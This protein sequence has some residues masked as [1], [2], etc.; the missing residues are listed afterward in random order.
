V[1][2]AITQLVPALNAV[3][4]TNQP[5]PT[6]VQNGRA[7]VVTYNPIFWTTFGIRGAMPPVTVKGVG[8]PGEMLWLF[9]ISANQQFTCETT[10]GPNGTW[11]CQIPWSAF[12]LPKLQWSADNLQ[13]GRLHDWDGAWQTV[14]IASNSC[15]GQSVKVGSGYTTPIAI[16]FSGT[17]AVGTVAADQ[18]PNSFALGPNGQ[19]VSSGWLAPTAGFVA[20]DRN[21]NGSIDSIAE[22]FGGNPGEG[23]AAL[24]SLDA[25]ADGVIDAA[26][27]A[28]VNLS[29]WRD[30][31]LNKAT[32]PGELV[33]LATAGVVSLSLAHD[34]FLETDA[35]GN[36]VFE[37]SSATLANGQQAAMNDVY[38]ALG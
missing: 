10:I 36:A 20:W 16:D 30:A 27:P 34:D 6:T 38:F 13:T 9:P 24:A 18:A 37:H 29:V 3:T 28:Y 8:T 12:P 11:S 2:P 5:L 31:N 19:R 26:D 32:D 35:A 33:S 15:M 17:G 21:A 7:Q 22:L 1:D 25:N 23:F 14:G 4:Y